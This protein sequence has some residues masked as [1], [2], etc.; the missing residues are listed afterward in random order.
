MIFPRRCDPPTI[1]NKWHVSASTALS[2]LTSVGA[3][4]RPARA[5]AARWAGRGRV[6]RACLPTRPGPGGCHVSPVTCLLS[7]VSAAGWCPRSATWCRPRTRARGAGSRSR[8]RGRGRASTNTRS[9][10]SHWDYIFII[11]CN[12]LK[13]KFLN[14]EMAFS[15]YLYLSSIQIDQISDHIIS[16]CYY[17]KM[18][19]KPAWAANARKKYN[20][21]DGCCYRSIS[22]LYWPDSDIVLFFLISRHV[23][24]TEQHFAKSYFCNL[25]N[26]SVFTNFPP[27]SITMHSNF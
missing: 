9:V 12:I 5:A 17:I 7:R 20:M 26:L 16:E 24:N 15:I 14:Y 8:G 6:Q 23:A 18:C 22:A 21:R 25:Q 19:W 27:P 1:A 13:Y 3:A 4:P 11:C 10:C 2:Q